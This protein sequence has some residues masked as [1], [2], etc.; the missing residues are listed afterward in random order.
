MTHFIDVDMENNL[1]PACT[2]MFSPVPVGLN[3]GQTSVIT[4]DVA[5]IG[6]IGVPN[7]AMSGP[8][9]PGDE[10]TIQNVYGMWLGKATFTWRHV[11]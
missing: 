1:S 3:P 10:S 5:S 6:L 2:M 7:P 11:S 4:N 8:Y 9:L